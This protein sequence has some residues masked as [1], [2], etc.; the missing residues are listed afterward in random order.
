MHG[1]DPYGV[2]VRILLD[3]VKFLVDYLA[4]AQCAEKF[5][6]VTNAHCTHCTVF[7]HD[8]VESNKILP[9]GIKNCRTVGY[10]VNDARH[11]ALRKASLPPV[12]Y[13]SWDLDH[14]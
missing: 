6:Y 5:G 9:T 1:V 8:K 10:M 7:K 3:P 12:M 4:A 11:L 13:K 2:P 14:D